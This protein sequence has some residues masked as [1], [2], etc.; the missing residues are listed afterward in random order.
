MANPVQTRG[1]EMLAAFDGAQAEL[2][3]L[4]LEHYED[5]EVRA[6]VEGLGSKLER[7]FKSAIFPNSAATEHFDTL[8]NR[9]KAAGVDKEV[10]GK[11]H[12]F[13]SLYNDAKHDP[14]HT[15]RLK[16]ASDTLIG[17]RSAMEGLIAAQFG[18]TGAPVHKA[19]SRLLWLSA[20]DQYFDGSTDMYVSLPL[21]EDDFATHL[22]VVYTKL[23]A[24]H[25]LME[26]LLAT[27]SLYFGKEHFAPHVFAKFDEEGFLNAGIWDGDYR[28]LIQILSKYE[29]RSIADRII[30]DL[31]R[32]HMALAVLSAIVLAGVDVASTAATSKSVEEIEAN[33]RDR[34]DKV[35]AMPSERSW[36]RE[37]A[38]ELAEKIVELPV[39]TWAHLSGPYWNLWKRNGDGAPADP[40]GE[41]RRRY[42]IDEIG[43]IVVV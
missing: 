4:Q 2:K 15:I 17:A 38:K 37:A 24:W 3:R 21:P 14:L 41:P 43:R 18:S 39:E 20:Y 5:A 12:T 25:A 9:L 13:R 22:D 23:D 10:R 30:P 33:I 16:I 7:F 36:V 40:G 1:D 19:V 31:R 42:T 11:L 35:Y 8:I 27:G 26:D 28:L 29:N 34:A 32:D 6:I